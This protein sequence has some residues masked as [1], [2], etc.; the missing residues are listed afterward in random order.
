LNVP[1]R[2][3]ILGLVLV[4]SFVNYLLRNNLS[5]A[6]PSIRADFHFTTTQ[7]GFIL[8]SFNVAYAVFQI[9]GGVF[10]QMLGPRK[11]LAYIAIAWGVL[12]ALTGFVPSIMAASA[13]GAMIGLMTVRFLLGVA[14]APLFPVVAGAFSNW[15]PVAGWAFPNAASSMALCLGQAS[16]GPIMSM[17]IVAFGWRQAFYVL[18]PLGIL[19][20]VWWWWY[21]RDDPSEHPHVSPGELA[22]IRADREPV[23][24]DKASGWRTVIVDRNVLLLAAS[25]FC[26]NYV[27]YMFAQ[28]LFT[29]LVEERGFSLIE[30]G[31]LAALPFVFGAVLSVIGGQTCDVLCRR[32]GPRWGCRLVG[33][34]G[35]LMVAWL[36][37]AG[38]EAA[39]PYVA[40]G[41]LSLCYGFTQ[42]T[43]GAY[44]SGTTY[45][46]GPYTAA[47]GGVLN[48]GGNLPGFLAP[49][50][51]LMVDRLGWLPT[52]ASG[53]AFAVLSAVLWL[54][55][56]VERPPRTA[57]A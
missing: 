48:T 55:I 9:P 17:L 51:G 22:L 39:N 32:I 26:M 33:V 20:G 44:W 50:I 34:S 6:L 53:S 1:V 10:G 25:Y 7:L 54:F 38:A 42:F 28:W 18:A 35:M 8:G 31:F 43:E 19:A 40:V 2:F 27:F 49:L 3:L 16:L 5:Y 14:N 57:S 46:A 45:V 36:L 15:F 24:P 30:S 12:T 41:L 29:Y 11:A 23:A 47:A 21:A 4:L 37:L 13:A 52:L 56:V